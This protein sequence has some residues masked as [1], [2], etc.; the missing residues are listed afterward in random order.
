M[1]LASMDSKDFEN[2]SS[3]RAI[4]RADKSAIKS[5]RKVT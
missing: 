1:R 5:Y 2:N 4:T 3:G